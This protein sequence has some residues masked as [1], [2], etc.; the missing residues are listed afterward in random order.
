M[1]KLKLYNTLSRQLEEFS[2]LK[3]GRASFY[4]CGPTV[5]WT[6]H[7]GNLRGAV[8]A[9]LVRRTFEYYGYRVKMARNYTDVGHLSSDEDSGEDKV[10]KAA[11]REQLS[12]EK[13][14]QKYIDLYEHD[15]GL[16][17][18]ERP[19]FRP[20]ATKHIGEM[21]SL[22][23][24]LLA[25]GY[26]YATPLAI[27][28]SPDKFPQYNELSRQD[29]DKNRAGEGRAEV[30]DPNKRQTADFALWFFRAG[31]HKNALQYWRSPF[32]SPLVK[33]GYGFPGWHLECSAMAKKY[34]GLTLDLHMGGIEHIP[35]H[36]TNEI[37]QSE[38]A[39]DQKFVNYWLHNAHLSVD[40]KKMSKS[41]G[42]AY[43][44]AEVQEKG[45]DPLVLRYFYLQAHYRS[46]QNFTWEALGAAQSGLEALRE[47]IAG[48][49]L[50]PGKV[51][52]EFQQLFYEALGN[53]VNVPASLALA[54]T[55]FKSDLKKEDKLATLL[56]FDRVWGLKLSAVLSRPSLRLSREAKKL[57]ALREVA[58]KQ[59]DYAAAD[60]LR[61]K[62]LVLGYQLDDGALGVKIKKIS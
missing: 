61:K 53:D 19:E 44:L 27:Y 12:P 20:R 29:L 37:A 23:K 6:Q 22:V 16:L 2:P 25:K 54:A 59:G 42:T 15:T 57:L 55:V 40:N 17:N 38:A 10:S 11:Q 18:I 7:I 47:K 34:L 62:L 32:Q 24:I 1:N 36:H 9:D 60:D 46:N 4:Y 14:A 39:N 8:C 56:D 26:A 41:E 52:R 58:R 45:F 5:Y 21:I 49:A 3:K 13:I 30:S 35:V 51:S 33:K 43:S 28:F 31:E 50:K 48:L